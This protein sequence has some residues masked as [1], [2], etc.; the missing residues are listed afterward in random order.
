M[1]SPAAFARC[2]PFGLFIAFLVLGSLISDPWLVVPRVV[3]VAGALAWFWRQYAEL[4]RPVP[5][6]PSN[7]IL[8]IAAGL[9]VF[10]AWIGLDQGWAMMSRPSGG[11]TPLHADGALNWPLALVRF[12][13]FA[14]V[15]PVMEELFWRSFLL[16]WL[17]RQEFLDVAPRSVG[18]RAFV[19]TT[20]LFALEH[21]QWLAG[22]LAG[23]VYNALYMRSGNLWVP[24][25]AHAVTNGALAAWILATGN[26]QFW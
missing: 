25:I 10:V 26:W 1:P 5:A 21:N 7:W 16:R 3:V 15:V 6:A 13:S 14:L 2:L 12:A 23:I 19:I 11:F 8:S 9:G 4:R 24:I 18:A 17:E 22:A 20:V